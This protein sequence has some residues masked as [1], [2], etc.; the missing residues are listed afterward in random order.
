MRKE[1]TYQASPWAVTI[2]LASVGCALA[3]SPTATLVC[4]AL[5][6]I[7]QAQRNKD[8]LSVDNFN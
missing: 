3:V 6:Y 7:A 8:D 4:T 5:A 2:P 1:T